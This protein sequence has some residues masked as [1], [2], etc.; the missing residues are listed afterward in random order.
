MDHVVLE[1]VRAELVPERD[2]LGDRPQ[3]VSPIARLVLH[4]TATF[5]YDSYSFVRFASGSS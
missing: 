5:A 1:V 2:T 4:P 3:H